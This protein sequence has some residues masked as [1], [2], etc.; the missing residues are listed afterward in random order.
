MKRGM[1]VIHVALVL[2]LLSVPVLVRADG[3]ETLGPP[4]IA[5]QSGTGIIAAGTGMWSQPGTITFDVP[6]GATVKQVLLYWEG[7]HFSTGSDDTIV[8][9]GNLVTG[10]LIGGPTLFFQDVFSSAFRADVTALNLVVSGANVLTVSGMDFNFCGS[11]G[12]PPAG[13]C[14]NNG[15]GVL[16]IFD[17][18][19]E[20]STI[21]VRDGLDLAFAFF[22]PPLDATVPQTFTFPAST[23]Q[24]TAR[25]ALFAGSVAEN[26][27]NLIRITVDGNVTE[28]T[29]ATGGFASTAGQEWDA[30]NI[31]VLIPAGATM[32]TVETVSVDDETE[33]LPASLAWVGAGLSVPPPPPPPGGGGEGCT[34][35]YWR[36]PV[37]FDSWPIPTDTAFAAI[38]SRNVPGIN[39]M[40]EAVR[41]R[42]GGVFALT[43][44]AAAAYL[45]AASSG[46]DFAFTTGEVILM[47]QEAFDS[48]NAATI[49]NTKNI[50]EAANEAGCPLD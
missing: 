16:V 31:D 8:V 4:S 30:L 29:E 39:T 24:R 50:L 38:F 47:F 32:M 28:L 1:G 26:R 13:V 23:E 25:L 22:S 35:G 17:D 43:R 34:P 40:L 45:N 20:A 41:A 9:N 12:V 18:G 14:R 7:Q 3:T 5:I 48:G 10:T 49:E 19:S 44:H 27:P 6:T 21:Q 37:H 33:R 46:V 42:G 2:L 15:V 36:V 11:G